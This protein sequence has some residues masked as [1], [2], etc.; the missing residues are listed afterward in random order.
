MVPDVTETIRDPGL[1]IIP[2]SAGRVQV[3]A[4]TCSKAAPN[5]VLSFGSV[6]AAKNALGSGP[7]LDCVVQ[8]LDVGG[9]PV[10][11]LPILPSAAGTVTGSFAQTGTGAGTVTGSTGPADAITVKIILGGALGTMTFQVKIGSGPYSPTITSGTPG[12]WDY[13]V[14]GA[15]FSKLRFAAGTYVA[16]DIYIVGTDGTATLQAGGSGP[17]TALN[18]GTYSPTDR[19]DLVVT[20]TTSGALGA[21][22]F[23]YSLDGGKTTSANLLVPATGKYVIPGTGILLTFASTFVSGDVYKGTATQ[24]GYVTGD[25]NTAV[26]ALLASPLEWGWIH[27]VGKPSSATNA[28]ALAVALD[29][30]MTAAFSAFRFAFG[31]V[32]CPQD[33]GDATIMGAFADFQSARIG[34][35]VGDIDLQSRLSGTTPKRNVAWAATARLGAIKLST[36]PARFDNGALKNVAGIYRDEAATPGLDDARFITARTFIS[37]PGYYLNN[38]PLMSAPG[39]DFKYVMSR[40]VMDRACVVA[41]QAYLLFLNADVRIDLATG[42]IDERDAQKIDGIVTAKLEAA[43]ISEQEASAVSSAVSRTDNLLSSSIA[44]AEVSIIPKAYLKSISVTLGF[45]NP[46][47]QQPA[48]AA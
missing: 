10:L 46:V 7:L 8:A 18:S 24:P 36:D 17:S 47:L 39:S 45:A 5:Q 41:R 12:P 32:E 42:Y 26:T 2:P 35:A 11:A 15:Y 16:N 27:V 29:S 9:G 3:K 38:F 25:V 21:A 48:A 22:T 44:N 43:L 13:Q 28:K 6:N 4:G 1:G 19:Y 33:E 14:P 40:R 37:V 30:Q 23:T 20:I 34:V 31:V